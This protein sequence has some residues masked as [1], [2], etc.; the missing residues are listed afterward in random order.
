M[1]QSQ[2]FVQIQPSNCS[3]NLLLLYY[4]TSPILPLIF[5]LKVEAQT[6]SAGCGQYRWRGLPEDMLIIKVTKLCLI[7][8]NNF[9][10]HSD[11]TSKPI[12]LG[13]IQVPKPRH[14]T[15]RQHRLSSVEQSHHFGES[16]KKLIK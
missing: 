16:L 12:L 4:F 6:P 3:E 13:R 2:S 15:E 7:H 8:H 11:K 14:N 9:A 1:S 5:Y 10:G